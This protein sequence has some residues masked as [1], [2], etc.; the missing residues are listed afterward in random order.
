ML[1]VLYFS[2]RIEDTD[3]A[4]DT[5]I[6][7]PSAALSAGGLALIVF[8]AL[9]SKSWGWV[10]PLGAPHINGHAITPL[11]LSLVAYLIP[12][13]LLVLRVFFDRQRR[14]EDSG[15]SPLL[16]V[17]LLKI[18]VLRSGLAVLLGQYFTI[19]AIFFVIPVYLQTILGYDALKTGVRL[20]P[21][22]AGLVVFTVLGSRLTKVRTARRLVRVG[23]VFL[24]VG[25]LILLG[26]ITPT[27]KEIAFYVGLFVVGAGFGLLA[28]QLGNVN[29]SAAPADSTSEVG[30]LQG[31]YQNLGTSFGTAIA[32]SIFMLVLTSGFI[33]GVNNS[34]LPT[35]TKNQIT[36]QA[37]TGVA[38]VSDEQAHQLLVDHGASPEVAKDVATVYQHAQ[39]ESLRSTMFAI[40]AV[41]ILALL[42]S[43]NLP[44]ELAG[45]T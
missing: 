45:E 20:L 42:L 5:R 12:A 27:L 26:A 6:D 40:F 11:G 7:V 43:T 41:G 16:K 29:M 1:A 30:G 21:L 22:S 31:T 24:S 17:S 36:T 8:G 15:G 4:P 39:I 23:Q 13:G 35:A 25:S 44:T 33:A 32:G 37:Q 2:G 3:P 28:S 34:G 9:Q 10:Q 18:P 38:I 14:L 19:A